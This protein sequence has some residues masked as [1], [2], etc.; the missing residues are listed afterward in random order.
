MNTLFF[1]LREKYQS[2]VYRSY[3]ICEDND[4]FKITYF[5]E[6]PNLMKFHPSLSFS[7]KLICNKNYNR[8]L[9]EKMTFHIGMIELISYY[10]SCCPKKI[11]VEAGYLDSYEKEWFKNVYYNGLGEFLYRNNIVVSKEEL[12]EFEILGKQITVEDKDIEFTG[13]GNLIPVGGGKDSVVTL[14]LLKKYK[15]NN[16]C[17]IVNPKKASLECSYIAGYHDDSI[18]KVKRVI[19]KNI[20]ELNSKGFLN[21]HIPL[22]AV[23]AFVSYLLAYLTNKKYIVLSNENS[24]NEA[25]VIGTN[26]NHQYSKSYEFEKDFAEFTRKNY[27]IDILYFSLL[28]PLKE[29]QIAMLFSKY[30]K[31]HH[32]FKSCNLGSKEKDWA[33]CCNCPKCLF[34]YIMLSAFL[35][36]EDMLSIFSKDMLDDKNMEKYFLELIGKAETKP[37]ECVGSISEVLYA[38]NIYLK[39]YGDDLP[40]LVKFYKDNYYVEEMIDLKELDSLHNVILEYYDIVKESIL[41][42]E[43]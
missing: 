28:R 5:F 33:W 23:F 12:F 41:N 39:K 24:A 3:D 36:K 9:V 30:T 6:I 25:T 34:V 2:I 26:V 1:E 32:A 37:F 7:K 31:Y 8:K 43:I 38:L 20:L 35:S 18:C 14:E 16:L 15:N 10:K 19:D 11:V 4:N 29:I 17:F 40:Y 27:C 13:S 22:S 42:Y 21:G